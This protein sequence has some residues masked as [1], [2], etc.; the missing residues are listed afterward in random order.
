MCSCG[1]PHMPSE[2]Y[3]V[4]DAVRQCTLLKEA[5][6]PVLPPTLR[7]RPRCRRRDQL[8]ADGIIAGRGEG[9]REGA[10]AMQRGRHA[11]PNA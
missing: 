5:S 1:G 2:R 10:S 4:D 6:G 3:D 7:P 9:A 8:I 11:S